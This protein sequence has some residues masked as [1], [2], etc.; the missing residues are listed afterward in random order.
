VSY[1]WDVHSEIIG[2]F[3]SWGLRPIDLYLIFEKSSCKNQ[4]RQTVFLA[5]KNQFRNW[6]LAGY[7]GSKNSFQ[8]RLKIQ[9]AEL[10]FSKLIFPKS[11]TDQHRVTNAGN[12]RENSSKQYPILTYMTQQKYS[13]LIHNEEKYFLKAHSYT[14]CIILKWT[15]LNDSEG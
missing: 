3:H 2:L 15:K 9:F 11:S 4:V 1:L 7:T 8:N 13:N 5:S 14:G 10:D 12:N 6:F